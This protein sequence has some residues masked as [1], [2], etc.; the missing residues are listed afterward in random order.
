MSRVERLLAS[1]VQIIR[2]RLAI[3][4]MRLEISRLKLQDYDRLAETVHGLR[5]ALDTQKRSLD[6][7]HQQ[8]DEKEGQIKKLQNEYVTLQQLQSQSEGA[9]LAADRLDVFK[10]L[11]SIAV[12]LPTLRAAIDDGAGVAAR[13]VLDLLAPFDEMLRDFGFEPIGEAGAQTPFDPTRHRPVGR[14][15][16]SVTPDDM[17]RVRYVGYLYNGQ[18]LCK[19]EVTHIGQPERL[20]TR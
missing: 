2:D 4:V 6:D 12:Q 20:A 7:V 9:S 16:H 18:V 3:V 1:F 15:A 11:Q 5:R 17:V 19:A 13:D 8:L 14:G 10:R